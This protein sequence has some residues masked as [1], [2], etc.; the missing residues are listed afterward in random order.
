MLGDSKLYWVLFGVRNAKYVIV[1]AVGKDAEGCFLCSACQ[2]LL[3]FFLE[4]ES[5][6]GH[7][8]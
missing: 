7:E 8:S 2:K 6:L 1:A 3:E 4:V 5:T